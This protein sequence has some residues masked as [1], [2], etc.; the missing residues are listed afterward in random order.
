M[1]STPEY[2]KKQIEVHEKRI[3]SL[4]EDLKKA[5]A[6]EP[7]PGDVLVDQYERVYIT[8]PGDDGYPVDLWRIGG[9]DEHRAAPNDAYLASFEYWKRMGKVFTRVLRGGLE[10]QP[11]NVLE[12]CV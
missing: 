4:R 12:Q 9:L 10:T 2:I 1:Y 3:A 8:V 11:L 7:R 5:E 6:E